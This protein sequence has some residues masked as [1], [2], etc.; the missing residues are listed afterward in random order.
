MMNRSFG[1]RAIV[2]GFAVLAFGRVGAQTV[3]PSRQQPDFT[4]TWVLDTARSARDG[5]LNSL[6]LTVARSGDTLSVL[7][8]G[9]NAGGGFSTRAWYSLDGK[10]RTNSLG[11]VTLSSTVQWDGPVMVMTS[12]GDARGN[13]VTIDDRWSLDASGQS[14]TRRSSL[15]VNGQTRSESLVFGRRK[16][17]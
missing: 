7:S 4:G 17:S 12:T 14:L 3:L 8:E 2:A 11:G 5:V 16:Q 13:S 9:T 10:P 6:V 1:L 15:T